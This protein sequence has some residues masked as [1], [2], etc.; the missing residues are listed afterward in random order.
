MEITG[1]ATPLPRPPPSPEAA[2]RLGRL[3]RLAWLLD[4]SIP[5]GR[6]RIGLDPIL[7]LIP[8]AGDWLTALLSLYIVYEGARLGVPA[9]ALTRMAGNILLEAL[10]GAVP[11]L[12]DLFDFAWQ[13]NTRN[14]QLIEQHYHPSLHA[15]P[16]RRIWLAL[17]TFAFAVLALLSVLVFGLVKM[18]QAL[19]S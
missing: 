18:L 13:A 8:G 16:L 10:V 11:L 5:V 19:F 12:G 2:R 1:V 4:R 17:A 15:R 7:G 14:L 3:R 6:W 9:K